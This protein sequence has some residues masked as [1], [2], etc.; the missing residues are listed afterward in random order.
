MIL[1]PV[2]ESRYNTSFPAHD[3]STELDHKGRTPAERHALFMTGFTNILQHEGLRS[4]GYYY[5]KSQCISFQ[6]CSPA[7]MGIIKAE[8]LKWGYVEPKELTKRLRQLKPSH[9]FTLRKYRPPQ[10]LLDKS[11]TPTT[12]EI[13][14]FPDADWF[15]EQ[16]YAIGDLKRRLG[17][18]LTKTYLEELQK[19]WN[20]VCDIELT[21]VP[22]IYLLTHINHSSSGTSFPR[23]LVKALRELLDSTHKRGLQHYADKEVQAR[24]IRENTIHQWQEDH[25]DE[26][27]AD[28]VLSIYRTWPAELMARLDEVDREAIREGRRLYMADLEKTGRKMQ[29]L[30]AFWRDCGLITGIR[31]P[32]SPQW[33]DARAKLRELI[34]P[35]YYH[36]RRWAIEAEFGYSCKEETRRRIIESARWKEAVLHAHFD[37]M[38]SELHITEPVLFRK[39]EL[40]NDKKWWRE[41][42]PSELQKRE[43]IWKSWELSELPLTQPLLQR[44]E[45]VWKSWEGFR[46][47]EDVED[48]MI[49][50][51]SR[52]RRGEEDEPCSGTSSPPELDSRTDMLYSR[53]SRSDARALT[54]G[55]RF[56]REHPSKKNK[57]RDCNG[58]TMNSATWLGR[59][60]PK[61]DPQ[62]ALRRQLRIPEKSRKSSQRIVKLRDSKPPARHLPTSQ[63][64]KARVCKVPAIL[65]T[66]SSSQ[67]SPIMTPQILPS[68]IVPKQTVAQH[69][70]EQINTNG[71][72]QSF[73]RGVQKSSKAQSKSSSKRRRSG[74]EREYPELLR[75]LTPPMSK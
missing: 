12:P 44:L 47:N 49:D 10:I 15:S 24:R 25:P 27:L 55:L 65:S 30:V 60:R 9:N 35:H 52:W 66:G 42:E 31:T 53:L 41:W 13:K 43:A 54:D 75:L 37:P 69:S 7:E 74:S 62:G 51:L 48:K 73:V 26:I 32:P 16:E 8:R 29:E 33:P 46:D 17:E 40:M 72:T 23:Y 59:P 2:N 63:A 21:P 18:S 6:D 64:G 36:E 68:P 11:P 67:Q 20:R 70:S 3:G 50:V 45:V 57:S 22:D 71:K 4:P 38:T 56:L 19:Y 5:D 34:A 39:G 28:D 61:F 14:D 58:R 1:D